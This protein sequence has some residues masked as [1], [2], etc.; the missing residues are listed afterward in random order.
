MRDRFGDAVGDQADAHDRAEDH[1]EPGERRELGPLVVLAEPDVAV[2]A[3]RQEHQEDQDA[4]GHHEIGPAERGCQPVQRTVRHRGQVVGE[5]HGPRDEQGRDAHRR[6]EHRPQASTARGGSAL[7]RHRREV[8]CGCRG[9]RGRRR[10]GGARLVGRVS[11]HVRTPRELG[12]GC[13]GDVGLYATRGY[14]HH[15]STSSPPAEFSGAR[16]RAASDRNQFVSCFT[17]K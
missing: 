10:H 11:G 3:E 17:A 8:C 13:P 15:R 6:P 16:R 2:R 1:R 12:A 9:R 7:G 14:A 5:Q 4:Q